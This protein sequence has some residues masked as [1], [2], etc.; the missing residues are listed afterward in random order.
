MHW[1][2]SPALLT[3]LSEVTA[4]SEGHKSSPGPYAIFGTHPRSMHG[5]IAL[6]PRNDPQTPSASGWDTGAICA[7]AK[8]ARIS[9]AS[10]GPCTK[11]STTPGPARSCCTFFAPA[12]WY[13]T[14]GHC[15]A[16]LLSSISLHVHR[17]FV[18]SMSC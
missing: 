17:T 14:L 7:P 12:S 6:S 13:G 1:D 9:C 11:R 5:S 4:Q 18:D 10:S 3:K 15:A 2:T 16:V 8:Q